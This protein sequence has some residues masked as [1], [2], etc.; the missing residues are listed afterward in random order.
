MIESTFVLLKGI[1]EHTERRLWENGVED[2]HAF[3]ARDTIPG[4]SPA[5]KQAY[6]HDLSSAMRHLREGCA[7]HFCRCLKPRDH[8][9]LFETFRS[10]AVFL[11]IETT[12]DPAPQ[13]D[14]TVVGLY[15]QGRMTSLVQGRSL[16]EAR[17]QRELSQY[18]LIVTF[19]GS[20]FDLPFLRAKFPGLVVD[21][22]HFDLCFAA[23]RLGLGGGLKR[24]E[25]EL[26][27]HRQSDLQGLDGWEAVRLWNR[28]R[29]G[30]ASA[31]ELLLRY[32]EA[33]TKNLEPL[34]E[35]LYSRLRAHYRG[36]SQKP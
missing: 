5:R 6:D 18:D 26:G 20:I 1:G 25:S 8:W 12:G 19:F 33:D 17:L 13:G 11:D 10:N 29:Q 30:Q 28:W 21:C 32:N 3:L 23:R 36:M 14:V 31:L 4:I 34:A 35:L 15:A 7:Q 16:T 2:W 27:I 22:P 9:R 24:I